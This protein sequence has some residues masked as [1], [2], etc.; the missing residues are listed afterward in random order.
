MCGNHSPTTLTGATGCL[1][2]ILVSLVAETALAQCDPVWT[3]RVDVPQRRVVYELGYHGGIDRVV[4]L[5]GEEPTTY[6][7]LYGTWLWDGASW[8]FLDAHPGDIEQCAMA[9]D[10]ARGVLV[11]VGINFNDRI[12]SHTWEFDGTQWTHRVAG[13]APLVGADD[14]MAYDVNRGVCVL[15]S[16]YGHGTWEWDGVGWTKV[17]DL[18]PEGG[19]G[20]AYDEVRQKVVLLSLPSGAP[21][22]ETYEWQ[23]GEWQLAALGGPQRRV[24]FAMA[25]DRERHVILLHGGHLQNLEYGDIWSWDGESWTQLA[26]AGPQPRYRHSMACDAARGQMV[27]FGGDGDG[28]NVYYND[29]WTWDGEEWSLKNEGTPQPRTVHSM[30]YDSWRDRAVLFSGL[31]DGLEQPDTWEHD[32]S[33]WHLAAFGGPAAR[34]EYG[35]AFDANRGVSVLFGG[36]HGAD[37]FNDTWEWDGISWLLRWQDGPEPRNANMMTYDSQ[38]QE[39]VLFGGTY[40]HLEYF[41]DTWAWDG[42][43]WEQV[44]L[45][46]PTPRSNSGFA[47]DKRREVIV[48]FGGFYSLSSTER[49]YLDDTWEWNGQSWTQ[50]MVSGPSARR[51]PAMEYDAHLGAVVLYGGKTQTDTFDD[52]WT[53]NGQTWTELTVGT[54]HP[55]PGRRTSAAMAYDSKRRHLLFHGGDESLNLRD[56]LWEFHSIG[57]RGDTN[58]DCALNTLDIE[59]FILALTDPDGYVDAYPSCDIQQADVNAD[60]SVN[61][62]DIDAFVDVLLA[63]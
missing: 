13:G 15:V 39:V 23:S 6:Q 1:A 58:C 41:G 63:P 37:V 20:V 55:Y 21:Q 62:L 17:S 3:R 2:T 7:H 47:F 22:M 14:D 8:T 27:I 16:R 28:I 11:A 29:T 51:N 25:Y 56:D 10:T 59:P 36:T 31:V 53:W 32:G 35:L 44:A 19:I 57:G 40:R 52:A 43:M 38:R 48:L 18:P 30:V 5:G 60:G 24:A 34:Y 42:A 9:Y 26:T 61:A 50:R 4:L 33:E 49:Y 46:G 12:S 54:G 45:D